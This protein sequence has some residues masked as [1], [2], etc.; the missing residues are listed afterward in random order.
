MNGFVGLTKEQ[1]V[2]ERKRRRELNRL[3]RRNRRFNRLRLL[4]R[5]K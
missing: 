1:Q 3:A 4:S 2:V 5:K